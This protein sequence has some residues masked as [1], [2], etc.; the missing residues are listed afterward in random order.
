MWV[1][2]HNLPIGLPT[3]IVFEV[4]TVI[5]S[6]HGEELYEGSNFLRIRVGVD[7]TKL[8]CGGRR[9]ILR[10]GKESWVSFKYERLPNMCYLCGKL[11]HMDRECPAWLRGKHALREVDQQFGSWMRAA[12]SNLARKTMVRVAGFEEDDS[13]IVS[14]EQTNESE[15]SENPKIREAMVLSLETDDQNQIRME[16]PRQCSEVEENGL[17]VI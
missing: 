7:V 5:E 16:V 11:T 12:T 14:S 3:S 17:R 6:T 10:S 2:L 15:G 1:Q 4:G 13:E 9:I 8:L